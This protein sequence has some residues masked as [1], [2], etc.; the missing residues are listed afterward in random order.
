MLLFFSRNTRIALLAS[1]MY[2]REPSSFVGEWG[3]GTPAGSPR[4]KAGGFGTE[5]TATRQL[6]TDESGKKWMSPG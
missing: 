2:M 4:T 3:G 1:D 5:E 6:K